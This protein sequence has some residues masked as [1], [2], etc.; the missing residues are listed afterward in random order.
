MIK[1]KPTQKCCNRSRTSFCTLSQLTDVPRDSSLHYLAKT[2]GLGWWPRRGAR[3]GTTNLECS[4]F[5]TH[6]R[7]GESK[8]VKDPNVWSTGTRRVLP[9]L[10]PPLDGRHDL[11]GQ[12]RGGGPPHSNLMGVSAEDVVKGRQEKRDLGGVTRGSV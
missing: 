6:T 2:V 11:S 8:T 1:R 9:R 3:L 7:S 5:R 12:G 4:E 10:T